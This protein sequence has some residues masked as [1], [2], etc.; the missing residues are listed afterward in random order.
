MLAGCVKKAKDKCNTAE[1][2]VMLCQWE[3]GNAR[4]AL[5]VAISCCEQ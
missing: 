5:L 2:A 1:I 4:Y 3:Q